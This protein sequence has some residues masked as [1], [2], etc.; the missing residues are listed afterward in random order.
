M[1]IQAK[2]VHT[3]LIAGDWCRLATFYQQV[4]GCIPV[5]PERDLKGEKLEAGTGIP[6]AHLRGIHLRL[7]EAY[8][9]FQLG[10]RHRNSSRHTL[11]SPSD[12]LLDFQQACQPG[13]CGT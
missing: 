5:P 13:G 6:G 3:N 4:F 10:E 1:S 2:Y 9:F 11:V 12:R 8:L 7:P